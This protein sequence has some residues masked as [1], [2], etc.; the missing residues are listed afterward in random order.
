MD[1]RKELFFAVSGHIRGIYP[2]VLAQI[3]VEYYM[4]TCN[5]SDDRW[6]DHHYSFCPN[7]GECFYCYLPGSITGLT[8]HYKECHYFANE[9]CS[10]WGVC[11]VAR[12]HSHKCVSA[13]IAFNSTRGIKT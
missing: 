7:Y 2:K 5:C 12:K 13:G 9:L 1:F 4:V 10:D 6:L 11:A 8:H 3:I